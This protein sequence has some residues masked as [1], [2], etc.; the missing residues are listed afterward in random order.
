METNILPLISATKI[1]QIIP[2]SD[3]VFRVL[4]KGLDDYKDVFKLIAKICNEYFHSLLVHLIPHI[5]FFL[6]LDFARKKF[7]FIQ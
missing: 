4:L 7:I 3:Q 1:Q 6:T 5:N 2:R